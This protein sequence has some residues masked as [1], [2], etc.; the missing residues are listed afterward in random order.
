MA[1]ETSLQKQ[2]LDSRYEDWSK[3]FFCDFLAKSKLFIIKAISKQMNENNNYSLS[4]FIWYTFGASIKNTIHQTKIKKAS[5][6]FMT[7]LFKNF[8]L[9]I[10]IK[11]PK[12][13]IDQG[14]HQ[15][16]FES[17]KLFFTFVS[18]KKL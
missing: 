16:G 1:A 7:M 15:K 9:K 14:W 5:I 6:Q 2:V 13:I 4:L 3:I 18:I 11:Q 17:Q 12:L 8:R 10:R